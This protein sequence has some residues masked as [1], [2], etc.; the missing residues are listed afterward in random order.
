M[1]S[2]LKNYHNTPKN[3]PDNSSKNFEILKDHLKD[4]KVLEKSPIGCKSKLK[5]MNFYGN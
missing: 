4:P 5:R 1:F 2:I 3:E